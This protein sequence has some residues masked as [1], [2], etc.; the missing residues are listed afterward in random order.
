M[1]GV[2]SFDRYEL[3]PAERQLLIEGEPAALGAR[4]FDLL[5]ALIERRERVV[6][7][8]E[9]FE[10]VWPGLVV[11]ENNLQVQVS[12]LRKLLGTNAIATVAGRGYQFVVPL[13]KEAGPSPAGGEIRVHPNNLPQWRTR[14]IGREAALADCATLLRDNRL[15]TL[16]GIGGCGKTRLAQE[17][18]QRQLQAFPDG[19]WFVDL[20]PL[21]EAHR[22]AA[23]IAATLGLRDGIAP[24]DQLTDRL[25]LRRTLLVMDNCEHVIDAAVESI[26]TL[27]EACASLKVVATSR[28]ALGVAGEQVFAVRSLSLPATAGLEDMRRSEAVR[29]FVDRARLMLPDFELDDGNAAAISEICRRLD[30]IALAIE[31]AAARVRVLPVE[32][33]RARL[34]DRFRLLTGGNRAMPRHQT[35][36]A[37][38]QWS[39]GHLTPAEQELFRRLAVFAGGSTLAAATRIAGD[40]KDEYDV[41]ERLTALHDKSLLLVDRDTQAQPRYRM[42]ETVRQYAEERMNEV[43]EGDQVRTRY[44]LHYVAVAEQAAAQLD[45]PRPQAACEALR[46]E[47]ENLVAALA[48]CEHAPQG[49]DLALRLIGSVWRYWKFTAQPECG[50]RLA[51]TALDLAG[52]GPDTID[53]CS[54][55]N[56]VAVL[57]LKVGRYDESL[58]YGER[59]LAMARRLN[60]AALIADGLTAAA[61]A[62]HA[63]ADAAQALERYS[64]ASQIARFTNDGRRLACALNGLAE[65]HRGAGNFATSEALYEEAVKLAQ[66]DDDDRARAVHLSNLA[67]LLVAAEKLERARTVLS[68]CIAVGRAI[69]YRG[70]RDWAL[71]VVAA[72]ASSLGNHPVAARFHGVALAE[73]QKAG[74][75]REPVDQALIE[76]RIAVSRATMGDVAFDAAEAA[77]MALSYETAVA[78]ADAW[79]AL[80]GDRVSERAVDGADTASNESGD[81]PLRIQAA[82]VRPVDGVA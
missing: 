54:T 52:E 14:F 9:L 65:V 72:L 1:R 28:E 19:V 80:S 22:V 44:L 62:L 77:G 74:S 41:L 37:T 57:S 35:L 71:D 3:R 33:I 6:T 32:D 49:G 69:G 7:K 20:G 67:G 21:Q 50:H 76:P 53:R 60:N 2:Y 31:L 42:L 40:T 10:A 13:N 34:D 73:R 24:L 78:E 36:Q 47:Q 11:E 12:S 43:G 51:R 8:A 70:V 5:L 68:E 58:A 59:C 15:L 29:L 39:H 64:E 26:E 61:V 81:V 4:A 75:R 79:L 66:A 63:K 45:G 38:M 55:L 27:L 18:A 82:I 48:W 56:G 16:T 30:G 25:R 46:H 17:L 23:T